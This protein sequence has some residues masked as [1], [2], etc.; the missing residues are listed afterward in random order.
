M[1]IRPSLHAAVVL[2]LVLCCAGSVPLAAAAG[3]PPGQAPSDSGDPGERVLY[4]P[5]VDAAVAEPFQAPATPYGPG[6]RGIDYAV[7]AGTVVRAAA[8]GTVVFA[9]QVAGELYVTLRHA[10]GIRTSYSYLAV[11]EV[12]AGE[13]VVRGQ[14]LGITTD[15]FQV[16]ARIGATYLDPA[17]LWAGPLHV[18][19]VPLSG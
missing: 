14:R 10:D 4:S 11:V 9:G 16:G 12:T 3:P 15:R 5:P 18:Y 1:V 2:L 6:N 13:R 19:L 7:A 8:D 17:S